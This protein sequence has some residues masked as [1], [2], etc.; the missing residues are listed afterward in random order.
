VNFVQ[1]RGRRRFQDRLLPSISAH[2]TVLSSRSYGFPLSNAVVESAV[3]RSAR[4]CN[5][6]LRQHPREFPAPTEC[7]EIAFRTIRH[8]VRRRGPV[9]TSSRAR[10]AKTFPTSICLPSILDY[11][12]NCKP[13]VSH[14][15]F[16]G[17]VVEN[18]SGE[19]SAGS[20]SGGLNR[21]P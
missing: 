9:R 13:F 15:F 6:A 19:R 20:N 3:A 7:P 12:R 18:V 14:G 17:N 10:P 16:R 11:S 21:L 5:A 1:G 8:A 2:T 4:P